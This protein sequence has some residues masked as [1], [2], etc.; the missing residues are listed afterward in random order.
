MSNIYGGDGGD[1]G[2]DGYPSDGTINVHTPGK[3]GKAII[4]KEFITWINK[5]DIRGEEV[6]STN[7]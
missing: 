6:A 3:A 2:E 4:G 7:E 5:G 1:L